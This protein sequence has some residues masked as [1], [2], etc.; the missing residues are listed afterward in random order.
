MNDSYSREPVFLKHFDLHVPDR[1]IYF[2]IGYK[3]PKQEIPD[4]IKNLVQE[5]R[6]VQR[7]LVQPRAVYRILDNR[8]MPLHHWI[9]IRTAKPEMDAGK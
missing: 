7:Q 6:R 8:F 9:K 1:R 2:R 5:L 3:S 4:N